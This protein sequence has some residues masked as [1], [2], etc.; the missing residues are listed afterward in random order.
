[1]KNKK[2]MPWLMLVAWMGFI[3]I[4]SNTNGTRSSEQSQWVVDVLRFLGINLES[5]LAELATLI[6]RKLAHFTEYLIL[7]FLFYK[8]IYMYFGK[9]KAL[10]IS[11]M[12]VFLFSC[13]DEFH[14][15]FIP[16]RDGNFKDIL[17]D[18]S[19]GMF[20]LIIICIINKIRDSNKSI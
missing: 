14:Q 10:L 16:G 20:G 19:G 18:T 13:T 7:Y 15:L 5:F 4:M 8:V 11:L 9:G 2:V 1:M 3:F 6:V 17:I 12:F